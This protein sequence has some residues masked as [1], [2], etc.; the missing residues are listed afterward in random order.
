MD[1]YTFPDM[2]KL[3]LISNALLSQVG[4][5]NEVG[6]KHYRVKQ[7]KIRSTP[8]MPVLADGVQLG[9]GSVSVH[10]QPRAL[11]VMT[12]TQSILKD[13]KEESQSD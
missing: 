5:A 10:I 13:S 1:V 12:G 2:S 7:I 4:L 6:I 3:N 8:Q 11:T 9:K